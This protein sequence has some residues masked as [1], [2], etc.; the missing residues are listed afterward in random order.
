MPSSAVVLW[1][2]LG[3]TLAHE[4][5]L[6][7]DLLGGAV[8]RDDSSGDTL[9]FKFH[10][11]PL[12]DVTTEEYFAAFELF[13]GDAERL[14]VGNAAKA[15]GYS[16]FINSMGSSAT[17]AND[18][19]IDLH[20]AR[21]EPAPAGG[22]LN[23]EF[24]HRRVERTIIFKVQYVAGGDDLVTVWL[25]PDLGPGANEIYQPEALTTRFS[26]DASFDKI[27]L[28]HGGG[29]DGWIFS[30]MAI[31]TSFSDFVDTSSAKP[32]VTGP[33][34][35]P[36][37]LAV[38][39]QSWQREPG[40][41][42]GAIRALAQTPDGYLWLGNDEGLSRFD[43]VRFVPAEGGG[44]GAPVHVLLGSRRGELW[45]GTFGRGLLRYGQDSTVR[46]VPLRGLP[47]ENITALAE[48]NEG[49]VWVG[50]ERGLASLRNG[51]ATLIDEQLKDAKFTS[52]FV[53]GKGDLW[54]GVDGRGICRFHAGRLVEWAPAPAEDSLES[55]QCL[56]VDRAGRLWVVAGD[57]LVLCR[58]GGQWQ[59]YRIP[60]RA[61]AGRTRALVEGPDGTVWAGWAGEGLFQLNAGKATAV[62]IGRGL[63]DN[64]V[65]AMFIDGEGKLW[66]GT[67]GG[68]NWIRRKTV[69]RLGQEEGLGYGAVLG[70]AE[71]VP[72]EVWAARGDDGMFRW[73]GKA[74]SR[75]P[76]FGLPSHE[77]R[78]NA[79]LAARDGSCWVACARG[80]L[81]FKDPQAVADESATAGLEGFRL[82]AL[83]ED[84]EGS[85]WA[86]SREGNL[87]KLSGGNW[88]SEPAPWKPRAVTAI[89]PEPNGVVWVG[90]EGDGLYRLGGSG[91]EHFDKSNGLVSADIRTLR[92]GREDTLWVGTADGG[93][94]RLRAG[95]VSSF[96]RREGLTENSISQI[97]EDDF[98]RLWLGGDHGISCVNLAEL[99]SQAAGRTAAIHPR[100]IEGEEGPLSEM[101]TSGFSPAG[102]KTGAGLLWFST[103]QGAVVVDPRYPVVPVTRGRAFLEEALVDGAPA[104]WFFPP[105]GGEKAPKELRV[106]AGKHRLELQYT[107]LGFEAPGRVRFRYRLEGLDSDWVDAGTRRTAFYNYVPPGS[108]RFRLSTST[109]EG[110]WNENAAEL[111]VRVGRYMWQSGWFLSFAAAGLLGVMVGL[112]R[113]LEKQRL[114]RRFKRMEQEQMLERERTRIARDLHDEM[115]SKLCRISFLSE[116]TRRA[117]GLPGELRSQI[118]S[119]SDESRE[120]LRSLDEIVWAANPQN[121]TLEQAAA[122]IG[123]YAQEYFQKTGIE[124]EV[125]MPKQLPPHPLSSQSRHHLF[126]AVREALANILKHSAATRSKISMSC[127]A[128]AFEI[129]AWDNGRGFEPDDAENGAGSG[130][131]SGNGLRNMRQRMAAVGGWC[132]A[133]SKPGTGTTIRFRV[134]LDDPIN[135]KS[136]I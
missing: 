134:P 135:G 42:H 19:Y 83:A 61:T 27:R 101:C 133:E 14:G 60:R 35:G 124:C 13:S 118:A 4:T 68:L 88:T 38:S 18:S 48:D 127:N 98:G 96:T 78:V 79:L 8:K 26:A 84:A 10:V 57:D 65:S 17:N 89:V 128:R 117:E 107:A 119:I 21:P 76:V 45:V 9:Y 33:G 2:D 97:L 23:Y 30:D 111:P 15:W 37:G 7:A 132:E 123:D 36:G 106:G 122:Y 29:G 109:S 116:H 12:S 70:L 50:T 69:F 32:G 5:G 92:S 67:E 54:A 64:A 11:S 1:S 59:R 95:K 66:V 93:L 47:S 136:K 115:G 94:S 129:C 90:T 71:V 103:A 6:G 110:V 126:L 53:D 34:N 55:P 120:V 25:N 63:L 100:T 58:E 77:P 44:P 40:M 56:I 105:G 28:R 39:V 86:G 41:P 87:W 80:L 99:D 112:I 73:E 121:D 3:A 24:P 43:G 114:H 49:R 113:L 74:F 130:A 46:F 104:A 91:L 52:L 75:L 108:Y 20:S 51:S 22:F 102:L 31:A 62:S 131:G 16:A 72:G 85:L 125:E 81:H 82:S